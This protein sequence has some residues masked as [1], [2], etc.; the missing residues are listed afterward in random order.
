RNPMITN[1]TYFNAPP[2]SWSIYGYY[3]FRKQQR[4]FRGIFR[5]ENSWLKKSLNVIKEN[6]EKKYSIKQA[7]HLLAALLTT[8][9]ARCGGINLEHL[10]SCS[11]DGPFSSV[12][13]SKPTTRQST[14]L[15]ALLT[16]FL[17][18]RGRLHLL[19]NQMS[20]PDVAVFWKDIDHERELDTA[21]N[22]GRL[23]LA[24]ATT[25]GVVDAINATNEIHRQ[26]LLS[27]L[28]VG[29][30]PTVDLKLGDHATRLNS[31]SEYTPTAQ[32][33]SSSEY[34][35]SNG[36]EEDELEFTPVGRKKSKKAKL[37][38]NES[39]FSLQ[40][41]G[42]SPT[43]NQ[44]QRNDLIIDE[45]SKMV[46]NYVREKT[47]RSLEAEDGY[48]RCYKRQRRKYDPIDIEEPSLD[49]ILKGY[50]GGNTFSASQQS[51]IVDSTFKS[52]TTSIM[53]DTAIN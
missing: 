31:S 52:D 48:D 26:N 36:S 11:V 51:C 19:L 50:Q 1:L 20:D 28:P 4:D 10:S 37:K 8:F 7:E 29:Y 23:Q 38:S 27:L 35:P 42:Q 40:F 14:F 25:D 13:E 21:R 53:T 9:L 2:E 46:G 45:N 12:S 5:N 16:I 34:I 43:D 15:A 49:K 39:S 17:A 18:R 47:T 22:E 33:D 24:R 30:S 3:K 44:L 41:S 32:L 6:S